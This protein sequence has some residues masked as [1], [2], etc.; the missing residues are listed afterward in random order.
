MK[1]EKTPWSIYSIRENQQFGGTEIKMHYPQ[2]FMLEK[3]FY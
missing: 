2:L 1:R 3:G